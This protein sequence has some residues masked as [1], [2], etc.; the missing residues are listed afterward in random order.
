M[1][2]SREEISQNL[3]LKRKVLF[4][5]NNGDIASTQGRILRLIF[6]L[7]KAEFLIDVMVH[8]QEIFDQVN[9]SFTGNE[10]VTIIFQKGVSVYWEP[11]RRDDFVK[12]F[13]NQVADIVIPGTDLPYWKTAAFDDF[14]GHISSHV[15][16]DI[17][18]DYDLVLMPV[19]S[20]DEPPASDADILTTTVLFHAREHGI[21][22]VG[23]QIY[24]AQQCPRIYMN[25]LDTIIVRSEIEYD[26]YIQEGLDQSRIK[27]LADSKDNYCI[28]TIE[29]TYKNMIYDPQIEITHDTLFILIL[30]H[31]KYRSQMKQAIDVI[32]SLEIKTCVCF[33]KS[34]YE[35]RDLTEDQIFDEL[36][37]PS[38]EKLNNPYYIIE[39]DSMAKMLIMC[40]VLITSTYIS[41][42][43]FAAGYDKGAII[44]NPI[45]CL[46]QVTDG[47]N[48]CG[49]SQAL[50]KRLL[51]EYDKKK[52]KSTIDE[53]VKELCE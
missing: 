11:Q 23:L 20:S 37:K 18:T 26:H 33:A 14:R 19:P 17:A 27:V 3:A 10:F 16:S 43:K 45:K 5:L 30:N 29:D 31:A 36:I 2:V 44:Y 13:I 1:A 53:I 24:P 38:L 40:D 25:M 52:A 12:I 34:G 48:Y 46:D 8:N 9:E 39:A 50:E 49:N 35:I 28:D 21:K 22:I 4:V 15:Y 42:Q 41:P 6:H 32:A 51:C 47:I 7:S